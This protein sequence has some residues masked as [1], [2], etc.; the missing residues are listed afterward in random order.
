MR[1]DLRLLEVVGGVGEVWREFGWD[2]YLELG[3]MD[4]VGLRHDQV[5]TGRGLFF[6]C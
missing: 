3:G 1:G 4:G 6:A 5:H 2:G